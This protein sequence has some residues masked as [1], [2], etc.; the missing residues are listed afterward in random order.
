M[1][2]PC[3]LLIHGGIPQQ[4][5]S[6]VIISAYYLINCMPFLQNKI[7][8]S[9]LFSHEPLHL[10]TLKCLGLHAFFI[11]FVMVLMNYLLSHTNV[12]F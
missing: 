1:E 6:D 10:L 8:Y 9:I 7:P 4:F 2:T 12:F 11:I 5:W 3:T